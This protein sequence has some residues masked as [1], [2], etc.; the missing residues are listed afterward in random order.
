[1]FAERPDDPRQ[2]APAWHQ[3]GI[4]THSEQFRNVLQKTIPACIEAWHM[5]EP[6]ANALSVAIDNIPKHEL[7]EIVSLLHD[8][9]KFTSRT[10]EYDETGAMSPRFRGHE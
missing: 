3:Y 2:H 5:S 8:I 10:L 4:L 6:V 7:L 9:G 1:A